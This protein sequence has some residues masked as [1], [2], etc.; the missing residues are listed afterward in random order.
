MDRQCLYCDKA[1]VYEVTVLYSKQHCADVSQD[2]E[3][4]LVWSRAV[5]C[6]GSSIGTWVKP[7]PCYLLAHV[8]S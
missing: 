7:Y 2:I 8:K 6:Y 1:G 5:S 4:G 3:T